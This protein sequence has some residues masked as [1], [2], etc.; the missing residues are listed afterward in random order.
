MM[1]RT[2]PLWASGTPMGV[3]APDATLWRGRNPMQGAR[4]SLFLPEAS[5]KRSATSEG[6]QT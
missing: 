5:N 4:P 6:G 2:V 1:I 3:E